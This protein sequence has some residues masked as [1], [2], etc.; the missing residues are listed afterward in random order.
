MRER[1]RNNL[2]KHDALFEDV[3]LMWHYFIG[4]SCFI[5][6]GSSCLKCFNLLKEVK[7]N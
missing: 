6:I 4:L 1:E 2:L 7:T 3:A 5:F